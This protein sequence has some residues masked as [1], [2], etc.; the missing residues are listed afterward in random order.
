MQSFI[1]YTYQQLAADPVCH[2][3]GPA[4]QSQCEL[5]GQNL[6]QSAKQAGEPPL[7][8]MVLPLESMP[9]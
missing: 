2:A 5:T 8:T 4:S 1:L 9:A 7:T 6:V 3:Y